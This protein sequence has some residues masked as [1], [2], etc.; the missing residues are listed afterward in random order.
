MDELEEILYS[1]VEQPTLHAKWLN[2]LSYMENCGARKIAHC[3]HPTKVKEEMLKHAAEEFRHAF[4]LKQQISKIYE[5]PLKNYSLDLMLGGFKSL[6]YLHSLD[7][8]T[9]RFLMREYPLSS[10]ELKKSA[11]ILV[12]YAIELRAGTL[13]P[14]YHQV[15]K[16]L[17]SR[18]QVKSIILEE[19]DHLSEMERE[20]ASLQHGKFLAEKVCAFESELLLAWKNALKQDILRERQPSR[21]SHG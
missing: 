15:L 7:V 2:T 18:V 11:Y 5:Q 6:H 12:T 21:S 10:A 20:I 9:S 1:I 14:L 4:Y 16:Q 13:Y 19:E 3:E 8:K 17:K